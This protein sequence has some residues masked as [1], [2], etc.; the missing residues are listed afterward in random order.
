M[1]KEIMKRQ[2]SQAAWNLRHSL[3]WSQEV[4]SE[5][6][7]ITPRAYGDWERGKYCCSA[8]TLLCFLFLLGERDCWLLVEAVF[9]QI[10][11]EAG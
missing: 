2:L 7:G 8:V 10:R 1:E 4:M 11:G 3:G 5:Y 6:L 9:T